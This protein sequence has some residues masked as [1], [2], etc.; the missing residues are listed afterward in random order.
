MPLT[1]SEPQ[2]RELL[3]RGIYIQLHMHTFSNCDSSCWP[4]RPALESSVASIPF[5]D[6][7]SPHSFDLRAMA[8]A[9]DIIT[10]IGVPLAVIGVLPIFYTFLNSYFTIRNITRCLQRNGL[11]AITR[12]SLMSGVV[13]VS[14]P[15][16][17]ITPLDRD[18]PD[19]WA[20][21]P[22]PSM[23]KGGTWTFFNWNTLITG[24]R[25]YRLQYSDDLQVPQ[26]D[27]DFGELLGFLLD[28]GAVP[29]VKGL[30]F[31]K[32][33]GLWTPS[34]T[35][36]MLSPDEGSSVL[37]VS[38][39]NDSDGVLSLAL[40][41]EEGWDNRDPTSLPPS[42]MRLK[43]SKSLSGA[44]SKG[45][46]LPSDE[47][48][49]IEEKSL[50]EKIPMESTAFETSSMEK[51]QPGAREKSSHSTS[52]YVPTPTSLR[53]RLGHLPSG[54]LTISTA[55]WEISHAPLNSSPS[56]KH[57]RSKPA[58]TW[59][60]AIALALGLS[61]ALPLYTY[62]L[63]PFLHGL[64]MKDT[65]PCG[66]LVL[67]GLLKE[68]EAP[69]WA[70]KYDPAEE[71]QRMHNTF[72]ARQRAIAAERLLTGEQARVARIARETEDLHRMSEE[73]RARMARQRE[74]EERRE[75]EAFASGRLEAGIAADAG[76]RW[77]AG[78]NLL[79]S[80]AGTQEAVEGLLIGM[81]NGEEVAMGVCCV[82]ERWREWS[83]RG[84]MNTEDLAT[85]K[86]DTLGFC[87]AACVMGLLRDVCAK[88]ESS[89]AVDM[90]E[91]IHFWKK[92]RL[93]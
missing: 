92:I 65:I 86:K 56:L 49:S 41:W 57:L 39:P 75:R 47:A 24:T 44:A 18:D 14:L 38:V 22:K 87:Y 91:V 25:L 9:S 23:L 6:F 90:Q 79:R 29:D 70:T 12:G 84:G 71:G 11:E 62:T 45:G 1:R 13:E 63:P 54:D 4:G 10:Y 88:E 83:D 68:H 30:H 77:L 40:R 51:G 58:S 93:G 48:A 37:R 7:C 50:L 15:R 46:G 78:Q 55:A 28:R 66:V 36:L 5:P 3:I 32:V 26:A 60:P 74:R 27:I 19:Y 73:F 82:L 67:L 69:D 42:W 81:V 76:I 21:N 89:V 53:F 85:F 17:S 80:A 20:P 2:V 52:S 61:K 16:F 33:S 35:S 59:F 31:L 72:L 8:N 34:G 64:A 43:I